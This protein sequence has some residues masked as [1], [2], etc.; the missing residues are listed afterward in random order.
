MLLAHE[1][2]VYIGKDF[3]RSGDLTSIWFGEELPD[4]RLLTFLVIELRNAPFSQQ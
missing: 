4:G 1:N 3:A 2:P